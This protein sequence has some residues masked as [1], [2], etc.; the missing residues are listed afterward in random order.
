[1]KTII[2]STL[3]I[4]KSTRQPITACRS[5]TILF[6]LILAMPAFSG[7]WT[8]EKGE[9]YLKFS[10]NIFESYANFD[11]NG[12]RIEPFANSP[13]EFSRFRDENLSLYFE[14]G[15]ADRLTLFGSVVY[16][17]IEQLTRIKVL[18][19]DVV[20]TNQGFA[21]LDIGARYRL[22]NGANVFSV[23]VLLK[24]PFLYDDEESFRL[25]NGQE[26]IELRGLYGRSLGKGFYTGIEAGYRWRLED[27]SDELRFLGEFG[28]SAPKYVYARTKLDVIE[29]RGDFQR[30][31]GFS[32]PLLNPQSDLTR[33]ELTLGAIISKTW[34]V[35]YTYTDTLSGKNTADGQNHQYA[36]V[37]S[38]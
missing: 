23:A 31:S 3:S 27:P 13:D 24:L 21:D 35:E 11:L 7:A 9:T 19:E 20:A 2:S 17:E 18:G 29:S 6:S 4:S 30:S 8:L 16:K 1:M 5:I 12:D 25:G 22:T 26:D 33:L 32:N 15:I 14:T 36:L 28:Y 38:F 10:A 34:Q 37:V